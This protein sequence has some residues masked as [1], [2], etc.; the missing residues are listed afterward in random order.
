[1]HWAWVDSALE[2]S[3]LGIAWLGLPWLDVVGPDCGSRGL[4]VVGKPL[5]GHGT[6]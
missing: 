6:A 4:L 2:R 3:S 1:M 5:I